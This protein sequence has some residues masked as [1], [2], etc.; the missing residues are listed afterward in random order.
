MKCEL[1]KVFQAP[2]E[3]L[4]QHQEKLCPARFVVC[5]NGC[6]ASMKL[7]S[8]E[9]HTEN[10]CPNHLVVCPNGCGRSMK[11]STVK[12]HMENECQLSVV[13]CEFAYAGCLLMM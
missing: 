7:S 6:G 2:L 1:C 5:P 4:K 13:N 8:V 3:E 10:K 12:V 11:L 9:N